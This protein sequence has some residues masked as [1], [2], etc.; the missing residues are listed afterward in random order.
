MKGKKNQESKALKKIENNFA[1]FKKHE[2]ITHGFGRV[3]RKLEKEITVLRSH[4][5]GK[6]NWEK[7]RKHLG[8]SAFECI[9]IGGGQ[10]YLQDFL[11]IDIFPPA[12]LIYDVRQGLP[13]PDNC[14]T[15]LFCEHLLEHI[16]Y[17][18]SIE[19]FLSECFR[20]LKKG[21]RFVI[22]VPDGELVLKNYCKND[23]LFKEEIIKRWYGR[24]KISNYINS[25][26]DLVNYHFRDMDD[27]K[28]YNPHLWAY[29][30]KNLYSLLKKARFSNIKK[31]SFNKLIANP[32]RKWGSLYVVVN[33]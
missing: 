2:N 5:E 20:V 21:G 25:Y 30:Y 10:H 18:V 11:N 12:D 22:G 27:D 7:Q 14:C 9:Q 4:L 32:K 19:K 6:G 13:L 31:W 16:D 1:L 23:Q 28:I 15:F 24:R 29:D 26:I 33:K 8:S 17:P 3:V